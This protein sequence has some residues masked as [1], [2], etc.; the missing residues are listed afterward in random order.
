[1]SARSSLLKI[2]VLLLAVTGLSAQDNSSD[3]REIRKGMEFVYNLDFTRSDSV[4]EL[5]IRKNPAH[6]QGYYFKASSCFYQIIS[7]YLTNRSEE[8]L[9][10]Y[11]DKAIAVA[12]EYEKQDPQAGQFYR[13]TAYG[14]IARY[15]AMN[16]DFIKAFYY[17]KKSKNLHE[18]IMEKNPGNYD[19]YLTVGVYNY[20]AAAIPR[21]MDAVAGLFGLG[22]N[23]ALGIR[24]LETAY[25]KGDLARIEAKF[26]LANVYY[27]EGDYERSV[28]FYR[29]LS[30]VFDRNPF[31]H[32]QLGLLY[33]SMENFDQAEFSFSRSIRTVN[34]KTL[35]SK[36]FADYFLGRIC[37]LR[38]DYPS[39]LLYLNDA[40]DV[41]NKRKLFKSIDAWIV[42]AAYYQA[43][44]VMELSGNRTDA[45]RYYELAK[46]H[47]HTGKSVTQAAKNRLQYGLSEFEI[48]VIRA[49]HMII[50]G[51]VDAGRQ[52]MEELRPKAYNGNEKFLSQINFYLG[53]S[54]LA[55]SNFQD[56]KSR[57][58][59]SLRTQTDDGDQ[60][61]REPQARFYLGMC[62]VRLGQKDMAR[63][64]LIKVLEFDQYLEAARFKFLAREL[65]KE[66]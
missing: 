1:M 3:S 56:A 31:L 20:Y 29:E 47:E 25:E 49:R 34:E 66:L 44:E 6:P 33:Y 30:S 24:Q 41:G 12:E 55:V 64:E 52:Y 18:E 61:W 60:K 27:E 36:I 26:F 14:N 5:L 59:E 17:A 21:W 2:L 57:F 43:G 62:Y 39:A 40:A 46:S 28:Q 48:G 19:A 35:S 42:G 8:I 15:H 16:G 54:E 11:N 51:Q 53:R 10:E 58:L 65:L 45:I 63:T 32:N 13:G 4:F 37:K 38:N 50:Y 23:R 9:L 7:G 22:G